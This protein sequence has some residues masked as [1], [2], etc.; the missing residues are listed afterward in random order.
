MDQL[1][2]RDRPSVATGRHQAI[3]YSLTPLFKPTVEAI[4]ELSQISI[5]VFIGDMAVGSADPIFQPGDDAVNIRENLHCPMAL[6]DGE[7]TDVALL[8]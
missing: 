3:E 7:G 5:E 1:P 8:G 4:A 2:I 6:P